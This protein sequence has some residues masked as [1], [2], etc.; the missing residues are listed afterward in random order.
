MQARSQDFQKEGYMDAESVCMHNRV[1]LGGS[2]GM[3]PQEIASEA[4]LGQKQ[5]I[6]MKLTVRCIPLTNGR[7]RRCL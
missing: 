5:S 4:T 7:A 1:R 3:L 2:G 6:A